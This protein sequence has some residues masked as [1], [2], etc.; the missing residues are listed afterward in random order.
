MKKYLLMFFC[1]LIFAVP[2]NAFETREALRNAY[3]AISPIGESALFV[4]EPSVSEP[5]AAGVLSDAAK[6]NALDTVNFLRAVAGLNPV[7][8]NELYDL[9]SAHAAVLLAANDYVDHDPPQPEDMSDEFYESAHAGTSQGN[10]VGLNWMRSTILTEGIRYFVR[11]DGDSNLAQLGHRRWIL[12]PEMQETGFGLANSES[13]KS[14]VVMYALDQAADTEWSEVCWPSEGAFPVELMHADLAWSISLNP[15]AYDV[16]A[17]QPVVTLT[18]LTSGLTF[19]FDCRNETGDGYARI[20]E[21][22]FG[23]GACII[24]RPDFSDTDFTDY[25][26]NQVWS[27][28]VAGLVGKTDRLSYEVHMA[29]LY[30]QDVVNVELNVNATEMAVGETLSLTAKVVPEY[31][32]DLTVHW[33]SSDESVAKVDENG[34]VT[35]VAA[36]ECTITAESENGCADT[37]RITV[38]Q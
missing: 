9:R 10:L 24:F 8:E 1:A 5:Y 27:V 16:S 17:S 31:A 18:E 11:D 30:V 6:Q 12:N 3:S 20:S 21:E 28:Q 2:A 37:C 32:D 34:C 4:V 13:G 26:Q 33:Q 25:T 15:E 35:A 29:S 7:A 22:P 19:T 14:Y 36:G 23:S 38:S